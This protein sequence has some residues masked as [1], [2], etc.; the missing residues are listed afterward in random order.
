M[1]DS[2]PGAECCNL[3]S[4]IENS[5]QQGDPSVFELGEGGGDDQGILL[6]V[7]NQ[8]ILSPAKDRE[9][10][11]SVKDQE[12]LLPVK[13]QEKLLPVIAACWIADAQWCMTDLT[14]FDSTVLEC[15]HCRLSVQGPSLSYA[16]RNILKQW[17]CMIVN[18][19]FEKRAGECTCTC[20][21][22]HSLTHTHTHTCT[23]THPPPPPTHTHTH[24][25]KSSSA[26]T[27]VDH[28]AY[29]TI[30]VIRLCSPVSM[31]CCSILHFHPD[32]YW[33]SAGSH[34]LLFLK[35]ISVS[36]SLYLKLNSKG[37]DR[38]CCFLHLRGKWWDFCVKS[39]SYRT[40]LDSIW[41]ENG[42]ISVS[43]PD[44]AVLR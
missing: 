10:L 21:C 34:N 11:L 26:H 29:T 7:K 17:I 19:Y 18:H 44:T 4:C 2:S 32:L 13:D 40:W 16:N 22:M 38:C 25:H 30:P 1:K 35:L 20:M 24:T 15:F 37:D 36:L 14:S 31:W 5:H 3:Y 27:V 8:E 33:M 39:W 42:G 23:P 6:P 41:G 9:I 43:S 28:P 12:F